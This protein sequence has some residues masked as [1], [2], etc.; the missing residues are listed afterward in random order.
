ME[1]RYNKHYSNYLHKD[2]EYK[3]Y[4]TCGKP[5]LIIPTQGGKFYEFE[6]R[7]LLAYYGPYIE[8]G[9][10]QIFC[11]DSIDY[12]TVA[13]FNW[14]DYDRIRYHEAWMNYIVNEAIPEFG[15]INGS[16]MRFGVHGLSLGALHALNL[17][18]RF[19]DVFDMSICLSGMYNMYYF[20]PNSTDEVVYL[21]SPI[22]YL[23]NMPQDHPFLEKYKRDDIIIC[24]GQGAWENETKE[25]TKELEQ[26]LRNLSIPA[27]VDFWGT[28]VVHDWCSW[29]RQLEYFLPILF[30]NL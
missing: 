15:S 18:L 10:I 29:Y 30:M 27:W 23:R 28:D 17:V 20:F 7:G 22:H 13:N 14:N 3:V 21:N 6:D 19:P 2:M 24:C 9:K 25:T 12:E 16:M 11:I 4:G 5:F 26:L 1:I 8:S